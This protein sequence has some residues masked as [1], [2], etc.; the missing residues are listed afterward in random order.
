MKS[1][2]EIYVESSLKLSNR[3]SIPKIFLQ[4]ASALIEAKINPPCCEGN[5]DIDLH[6]SADNFFTLG[7]KQLLLPMNKQKNL[8]ALEKSQQLIEYKLGNPCCK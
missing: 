6:T 2:L 7:I 4:R 8:K 1:P 5:D 3:G